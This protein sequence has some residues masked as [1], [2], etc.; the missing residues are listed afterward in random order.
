[1][2]SGLIR[3]APGAGGCTRMPMPTKPRTTAAITTGLGRR[4]RLPSIPIRII[5]RGTV[6]ISRAAMLE[7]TSCSA[8]DT[9]PLP[10]SSRSAPTSPA[11]SQC[12]F[13]G[14]AAPVSRA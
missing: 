9:R 7:S 5:H 2:P 1:M 12:S 6:A 3:A 11:S 13:R 4:P 8:Q 10:P 14:R